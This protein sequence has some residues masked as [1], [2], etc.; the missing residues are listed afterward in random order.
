MR[1]D[2]LKREAHNFELILQIFMG[3]DIFY[4]RVFAF[5]AIEISRYL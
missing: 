5:V 2:L 3:I 1:L 4:R